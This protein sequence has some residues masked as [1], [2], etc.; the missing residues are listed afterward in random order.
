MCVRL[1]S[2]LKLNLLKE[3]S[4]QSEQLYYLR[5]RG[6][7]NWI[8]A[9]PAVE[10][11]AEGERTGAFESIESDAFTVDAKGNDEISYSDY[12]VGM[13]A[14]IEVGSNNHKRVDIRH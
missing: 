8:F 1:A 2:T 11:D 14:L 12:A 4:Q 5:T 6:D 7:F 13:V 9:S 10:F 3:N